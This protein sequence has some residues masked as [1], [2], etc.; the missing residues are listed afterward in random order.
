MTRVE[1]QRCR[2]SGKWLP[3]SNMWMM[4][5]RTAEQDRP[6]RILH[7]EDNPLDRELVSQT[8]IGDKLKCEFV[9]AKNEPE[10]RK[11][12]SQGDIDLI[13]SDFTLPGYDGMR[14]LDEARRT[15]PDVP[16]VFLSGTIGDR[17]STR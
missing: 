6:L 1:P 13:L 12:L 9:Y 2:T 11:A 10:F 8:L 16:F 15:H 14:A 3:P 4:G 17:K 7:L 5:S